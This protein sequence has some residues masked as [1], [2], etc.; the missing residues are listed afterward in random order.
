M[1]SSTGRPRPPGLG[2]VVLPEGNWIRA[3][4]ASG[5]L[6]RRPQTL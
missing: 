5:Q 4:G 2:L 1:S 6:K 3:A